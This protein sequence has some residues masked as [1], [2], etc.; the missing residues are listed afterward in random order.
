MFHRKSNRIYSAKEN[1]LKNEIVETKESIKALKLHLKSFKR[2]I[3][4]MNPN[5]HANR[6]NASVFFM[7]TE[8]IVNKDIGELKRHLRKLKT[9]KR[10]LWL[11]HYFDFF[12]PMQKEGF[13]KIVGKKKQIK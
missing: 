4:H 9:E 7:H 2:D 3:E 8:N 1:A 6:V 10:R 13:E 12:A 11:N 5:A